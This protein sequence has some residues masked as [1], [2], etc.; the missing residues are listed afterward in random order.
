MSRPSPVSPQLISVRSGKGM[1]RAQ[2]AQLRLEPPGERS[3]RVV[4]SYNAKSKSACMLAAGSAN[5]K[6]MKMT[7]SDLI[8]APSNPASR[9]AAALHP[10]EGAALETL[11][12]AASGKK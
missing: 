7:R 12:A 2:A 10:V 4:E 1:R 5:A 6:K 3:G 8:P 11:H 9:P